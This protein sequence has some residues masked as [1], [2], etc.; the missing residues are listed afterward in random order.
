M[1]QRRVQAQVISET[2]FKAPS[3]QVNP[4]AVIALINALG[5]C[6]IGGPLGFPATAGF[7]VS[8]FVALP[9]PISPFGSS[10]F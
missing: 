4:L 3:T 10:F 1:S 9:T 6:P 7:P 5:S 2:P 8:P